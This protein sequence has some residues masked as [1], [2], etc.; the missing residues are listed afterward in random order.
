MRGIP[1]LPRM[2]RSRRTPTP[3]AAE[4][5]SIR[6]VSFGHSELSPNR[7]IEGDNLRVMRGLPSASLDLIYADPPF[8]TGRRFRDSGGAIAWADS[9][10]GSVATYLEWM[11]PRLVEMRRLLCPTGSLWLHLDWHAVH[12][13]KVLADAVFGPAR[14]RNQVVWSYGTSARGAKAVAGHLPR[15]HD[16]LLVYAR[17]ARPVYNPIAVER[18]TPI[19]A[20]RRNGYLIDGDG[21]PFKTA[22]RGDYTDASISVLERQGRIYRTRSG[23][24]RIKYPLERRGDQIVERRIIGDVWT[25][26]PDA[27]HLP[28]QERTG[29]PTQKPAALLERIIACCTLPGA[30]VGDMFCGSGVTPLAAQRLGRRWLACDTQPAAVTLT[31]GRLAALTGQVALSSNHPP[32]PDF[33]VERLLPITSEENL[34]V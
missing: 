16:V 32:T 34:R 19:A 20:A 7:L 21:H 6:R 26:I 28:R 5:E 3:P 27:M 18:L 29:Y 31:A 23:A 9:S 22:P 10:Q 17:G 11:H 25:D 14:F 4:F 12:H 15:N 1:P 13:V 24:V 33:T 2:R 8:L 30:A